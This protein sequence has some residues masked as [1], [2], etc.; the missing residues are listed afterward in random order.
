VSK[1][2]YTSNLFNACK[3]PVAAVAIANVATLSG[4]QTISG[5]AVPVKS[6]VLLMAQTDPTENGVWYIPDDFVDHLGT[7]IAQPWVRDN[8]VDI[9]GKVPV[10]T[11]VPVTALGEIAICTAENTW[12]RLTAGAVVDNSLSGL[13]TQTFA[14]VIASEVAAPGIP[15]QLVVRV[16]AAG[17]IVLSAMPYD[18]SILNVQILKDA[19][20]GGAG[21]FLDI[22]TDVDG[23]T[24][25]VALIPQQDLNVAASTLL[26][27]PATIDA[28]QRE[29][30][31]GGNVKVTGTEVT[32]CGCTVVLTMARS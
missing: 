10:G 16:A 28:A 17:D 3:A 23:A 31:A 24:G 5:T 26:A 27:A 19:A 4:A 7:S 2:P 20:A 11:I 15:I 18:V 14:P 21:D 32:D 30:V 22:A 12:A 6:R 25:Y 9:A 1:Q 29:V 8:D 13:E